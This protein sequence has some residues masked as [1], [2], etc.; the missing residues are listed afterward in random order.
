V[1]LG[2]QLVAVGAPNDGAGSVSV[3]AA[4]VE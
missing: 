1:A 2:H 3:F 4:P